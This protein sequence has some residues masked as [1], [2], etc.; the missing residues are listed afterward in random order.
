MLSNTTGMQLANLGYG[1]LCRT[2]FLQ[3]ID[4]KKKN[5]KVAEREL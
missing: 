2:Y 3:Q 1:I 4:F 5:K